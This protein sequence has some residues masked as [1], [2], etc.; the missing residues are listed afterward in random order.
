MVIE[1]KV[2]EEIISNEGLELSSPIS[3]YVDHWTIGDVTFRRSMLSTNVRVV[4]AKKRKA[5]ET[6]LP[7]SDPSPDILRTSSSTAFLTFSIWPYVTVSK[8]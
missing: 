1:G 8:P 3:F 7:D 4:R 6:L 5:G 2:H